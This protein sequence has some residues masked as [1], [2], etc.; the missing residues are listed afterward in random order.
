VTLLVTGASGYLGREVMGLAAA[1]GREVVGTFRSASTVEGLAWVRAELSDPASVAALFDRVRPTVVLHLAAAA[2][3]DQAS[4][5]DAAGIVA[6]AAVAYGCRLVHLSTDALFAGCTVDYDESAEPDPVTPYGASKAAGERLVRR[7]APHASVVRTS[8]LVSNGSPSPHSGRIS[9]HEQTALDLARGTATGALFSDEFRCPIAV[10]D[11]AAAL[12]E[13][14]DSDHS[15]VINIAGPLRVS[16]YQLGLATLARYGLDPASLPHSTIAESG[17]VRNARV[18]LDSGR[19][20]AAL[21]TNLSSVT[22]WLS[23]D[24]ERAGRP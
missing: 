19:A 17:L 18:C 16:R 15:G 6:A 7:A 24:A 20:R 1:A 12:L 5:V 10:G 11:L 23:A 8:L 3:P 9:K 13:L 4:N 2:T 22:A 21:R 14:A